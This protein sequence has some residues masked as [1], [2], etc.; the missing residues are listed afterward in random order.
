MKIQILT[1]C[2]C[3]F[4]FPSFFFFSS[5]LLSREECISHTEEAVELW[6]TD[7]M[8]WNVVW[9]EGDCSCSIMGK[10]EKLPSVT[11]CT[12]LATCCSG[13]WPCTVT[14]CVVWVWILFCFVFL[15]S[16][17]LHFKAITKLS[18]ISIFM[19]LLM[20]V[21]DI[22]SL[23]WLWAFLKEPLIWAGMF[24]I[25]ADVIL[26]GT[27]CLAN[28]TEWHFYKGKL[29]LGMIFICAERHLEH[30]SALS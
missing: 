20:W 21:C 23:V 2:F 13:S 17:H 24:S 10:R 16:Q 18:T 1:L 9:P 27:N 19:G 30:Q 3:L 25:S 11:I 29:E 12:I 14:Q 7:E 22:F 4:F 28:E 5:F 6:R 26:E 15:G 8:K